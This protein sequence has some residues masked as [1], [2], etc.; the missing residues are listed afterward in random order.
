MR[1]VRLIGSQ[2]SGV[3]QSVGDRQLQRVL[4][5][6]DRI[7]DRALD[8]LLLIRGGFPPVMFSVTFVPP[9]SLSTRLVD[10]CNTGASQ[11]ILGFSPKRPQLSHFYARC[12]GDG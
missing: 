4:S 12:H 1:A 6:F 11:R 3:Q 2:V 9:V 10:L 5:V 7:P 8:K